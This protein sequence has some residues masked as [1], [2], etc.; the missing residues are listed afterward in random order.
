MILCLLYKKIIDR[1]KEQRFSGKT[2]WETKV[3]LKGARGKRRNAKKETLH[4][5]KII[6]TDEDFIISFL[7]LL[8][9]EYRR[10]TLYVFLKHNIKIFSYISVRLKGRKIKRN[11]WNV[12]RRE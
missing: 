9:N 4:Q 3:S 5:V 7:L 8:P 2:A 10:E 12:E 1:K 11:E 6:L